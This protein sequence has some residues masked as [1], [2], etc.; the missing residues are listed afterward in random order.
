MSEIV[1]IVLEILGD[2]STITI[3]LN[4]DSLQG[5]NI[6]KARVRKDLSLAGISAEFDTTKTNVTFTNSGNA[7]GRTAKPSVKKFPKKSVA[8]KPAKRPVVKRSQ[9]TYVKPAI[10]NDI[11]DAMIDEAS[12]VIWLKGPTGTGKTVLVHYLAKT[13]GMKLHQLNCHNRM[14]DSSFFGEKTISIDEDSQQNHLVFQEGIVT[15]AMRCGLDEN[16][17]EVG[18]PALL[19]IDEAGAMPPSVAIALNRFLESDDPRRTITLERNGGEV[20][21]S[22]SG[23]RIILAANTAGRGATDMASAMYTAQKEALD[24]SLLNRIALTF[25][26]GYSR[27]VEKSIA[28]EKIGNDKVV[29]QVLKY[30]DAIRASLR[31]GKLSTPFSTRSI[32]QIADAYRIY[33]DLAKAIYYTTFE[34]LLPEEKAIYNEKSVALLG[35][36]INKKFIDN[37]IDYMD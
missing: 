15:K 8:K 36:D 5:V 34:Q 22:H 31:A 10:A 24:I 29:S 27:N 16:G 4:D 14:D 7:I 26:F 21:R 32:V 11:M 6:N 18:A 2:S 9:H 28:M 23:L 3:S 20:V 17:N 19:F 37:D 12:H 30:R 25:K 35:V 13:L 33:D 1:D